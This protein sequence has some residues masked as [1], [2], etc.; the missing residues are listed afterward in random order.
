[1][2]VSYNSLAAFPDP[3]NVKIK[4]TGYRRV[5]VMRMQCL[6]TGCWACYLDLREFGFTGIKTLNRA[7]R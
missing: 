6:R 3:K 1:M 4:L 7:K 2:P 5:L